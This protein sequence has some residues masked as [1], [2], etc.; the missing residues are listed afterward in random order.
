MAPSDCHPSTPDAGW[1][2]VFIV[3]LNR[4]GRD[5]TLECLRSLEAVSY[6][7]WF[8]IVIDN[9]CRDFSAAELAERFPRS[10][11]LRTERNL[12]FTGGVNLGIQHAMALGA[13]YVFLLNN[14]TRVDPDAITQLIRVARSDPSIGIVGA[15]LLQL[16]APDHL[17]SAGVRVDVAWGRV[18][19]IG[20]GE[21]DAGQ[22]DST[23]DVVVSGAAMLLSRAACDRLGDFDERYF[24][25]LE[26]IDFCLRA[27][28]AGFRVVLAPRARVYHKGKGVSAGGNSPLILYYTTRNHL[29]LMR[30]Y[31]DG[32]RLRRFARAAVVVTLNL[33]YAL[34]RSGPRPSQQLRAVW[35]ALHDYRRGVVGEVPATDR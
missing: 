19:Q 18:Y 23:A 21:R 9:G 34:L 24:L 20:F 2:S 13:E 22:Y 1:P 15:K 12:G 35:R 33:A 27:R 28:R 26:D 3:V 30:T 7:N 11:Y 31:G 17:E 4:H 10:H 29:M 8:A 14:D 25:Y 6:S 5:Y 32:G 16:D